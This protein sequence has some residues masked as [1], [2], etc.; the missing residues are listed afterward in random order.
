M[1]TLDFSRLLVELFIIELDGANPEKD[2]AVVEHLQ[3]HGYVHCNIS[4]GASNGLF[5]RRSDSARFSCPLPADT[6]SMV[7]YAKK[8]EQT[9]FT[10]I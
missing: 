2:R 4:L 9:R 8:F 3:E 5:V 1:R 10:A 6:S 7:E